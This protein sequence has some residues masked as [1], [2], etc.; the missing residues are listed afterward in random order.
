MVAQATGSSGFKPLTRIIFTAHRLGVLQRNCCHKVSNRLRE[1]FSLHPVFT[2]LSLSNTV[3]FKPL[4]RIIFTAPC[5]GAK[6]HTYIH[7]FQT[8]YANYFHCTIANVCPAGFTDYG[9]SNRLRELFSLHNC[10]YA[11]PVLPTS[12]F[13][14]A[15]ANYFHCT[16]HTTAPNSATTP[17][18]TAYANYFHCTPCRPSHA[19]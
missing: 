17:F 8:A 15:Y 5:C 7:E 9:V 16:P 12:T 3:G 13:Q 11:A 2:I 14:T 1:L 18:Q 4:T 19:H 6:P 10:L